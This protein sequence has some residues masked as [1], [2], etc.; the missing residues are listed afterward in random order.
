MTARPS[1]VPIFITQAGCPHRCLF[2]NGGK[3]AGGKTVI[4][5]EGRFRAE[6]DEHLGR[7]QRKRPVR[8]IAFYGGNFT[9]LEE[10][11]QL[12]LL[13]FAKL[14]ID[15]GYIDSIRVSTRPDYIHER[16]LKI[17][18]EHGVVTVE[19]GAQ[20][21]DDR[22]LEMTLRGHTA[23]DVARAVSMLKSDGFETGIHL[24]AGLPGDSR[25]GFRRSVEEVIGLRPDTVRIHPT[26]VFEDTGLAALYRSGRYT[27]LSLEESLDLCKHALIRFTKAG[28]PVIRLGLQTTSEMEASGSVLAGPYHPA[29]RSIVEG[30][31]FHDM[32]LHLSSLLA[33]GPGKDALRFSMSPKDVSSFIGHRGENLERLRAK[34]GREIA[35]GTD[36]MMTRGALALTCD[37]K[38]LERRIGDLPG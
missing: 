6:V 8:Q 34:W 1:I 26:L 30:G 33:E 10:A 19:V 24:M 31:L 36:S 18:R 5:T 35:Y 14:Y 23:Q 11:R 28:I 25:A 12:E 3:I 2:C 37:G 27:P 13:L 15:R 29:F 20:S 9:G 32:A 38:T 22:V 4:W 21:M 17:L 16:A 7:P